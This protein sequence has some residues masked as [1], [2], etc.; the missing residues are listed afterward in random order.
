MAQT[1]LTFHP[2][3]AESESL[4]GAACT[5]RRKLRLIRSQKAG[6]WSCRLGRSVAPGYVES[7][8]TSKYF[9]DPEVLRRAIERS[10]F[11]RLGNADEVADVVLF[12]AHQQRTGLPGSHSTSAAA[13]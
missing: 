3:Q 4:L 2:S 6:R 9:S 1:S 7:D 10:P 12:C 8:M 13:S 11:G 5:A